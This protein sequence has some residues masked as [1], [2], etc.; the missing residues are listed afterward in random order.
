MPVAL[1]AHADRDQER[2]LRSER[3]LRQSGTL[4]CASDETTEL[5]ISV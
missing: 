3:M 1:D 4:A 5:R 2:E